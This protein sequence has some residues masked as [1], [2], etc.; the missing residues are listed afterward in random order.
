MIEDRIDPLLNFADAEGLDVIVLVPGPNLFYLTGQSF[1][2]SE[3]PVMGIFPVAGEPAF[4]LPAL[5]AGKAKNV[6]AFPYTDADGY[7]TAFHDACMALGLSGVRIGVETL[8]MRLLE[9]RIL[10][11]HASGAVLVPADNLIARLRILKSAS[12]LAAMREA[13]EVAQRAFLAWLPVLQVGMTE[14]EAAA[15][16]VAALLT[17][18]ADDLAFDPIVAGG[19]HGA[20][21]HAVPGARVFAPGDWVVVDWGATVDGYRSDITRMVVFGTSSVAL[22]EVH[23]TVR[24][25]NAAGREAVKPG[26]TVGAVDA[27]A[28]TLIDAAGYGLEFVHRTGHGL[29]LEA[30]EPP[31]IVPEGEQVL[32]PGMT[33]TVEPGIYLEGEAGFRVEDDV[34]VTEAGVETLTSLSREPFLLS[35]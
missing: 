14:K 32:S 22:T 9:S 26:V 33:F 15:R 28:R 7:E 5:E 29:G 13:V 10:A 34:L 27:A 30:H 3:R 2:L 19:P 8:R 6:Q 35:A 11:R 31:Y 20:L 18:G 21:P 17:H 16:L 25:A 12:E 23:E 1:H 24:R 4:V